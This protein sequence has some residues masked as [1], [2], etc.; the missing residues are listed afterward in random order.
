[1]PIELK[2]VC[3]PI[4]MA[5]LSDWLADSLAQ[6]SKLILLFLLL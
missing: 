6:K 4:H 2:P 5:C 1:L 3:L